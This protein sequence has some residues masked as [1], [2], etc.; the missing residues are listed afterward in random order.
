[1]VDKHPTKTFQKTICEQ[2]IKNIFVPPF[3][4]HYLRDHA[5]R[6]QNSL[7]FRYIS[8]HCAIKT[9]FKFQNSKHSR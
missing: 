3:E 6:D 2:C 5:L 1:M 4:E 7:D 9:F 8:G